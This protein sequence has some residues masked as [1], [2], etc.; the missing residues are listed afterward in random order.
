MKQYQSYIDLGRMMDDI[1]SAA[2]NIGSVFSEH[3]SGMAGAGR[4]GE[5][6]FDMYPLYTYPP[7][8]IYIRDDRT[9]V[10]EFALAGFKEEH[11][12]V[13]FQGDYMLLSANAP[14]EQEIPEDNRHYLKHRLRLKSIAQQR[15]FVPE[16]KFDREQTEAQYESG[17]LRITVAPRDVVATK[18]NVKVKIN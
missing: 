6:N 8:N 3:M 16:D 15:Y 9:L 18:N 13:Q 1:F 17:I 5:R 4:H 10:F 14:G 7:A 2:E 12:D 11:I